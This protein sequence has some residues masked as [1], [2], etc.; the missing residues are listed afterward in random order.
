MVKIFNNPND[1]VVNNFL[2]K[3]KGV[4]KSY[5]NPIIIEYNEKDFVDTSHTNYE[6]DGLLQIDGVGRFW[7]TDV[8]APKSNKGNWIFIDIRGE[9]FELKHGAV[10]SIDFKTAEKLIYDNNDYVNPHETKTYFWYGTSDFPDGE[11]FENYAV[12]RMLRLT[13][14]VYND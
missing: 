14:C 2:K 10:C 4:I 5:G 6:I 9:Q 11:R 13:K 1:R 12:E 8:L 7:F 3:S